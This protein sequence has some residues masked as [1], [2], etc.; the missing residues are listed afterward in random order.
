[1]FTLN[2]ISADVLP[3]GAEGGI[4]LRSDAFLNQPPRIPFPDSGRAASYPIE[5]NSSKPF[6][7]DCLVLAQ[8]DELKFRYV[9]LLDDNTLNV[10]RHAPA[11]FTATVFHPP[12]HIGMVQCIAMCADGTQAPGCVICRS[13]RLIGKICC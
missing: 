13:G 6:V 5:V 9:N 3:G 7:L 2:V 11:A 1:M 4:L 8:G 12:E 10:V